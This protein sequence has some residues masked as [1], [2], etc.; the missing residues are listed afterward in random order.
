M[1]GPQTHPSSVSGKPRQNIRQAN[2]A[3]SHP[4]GSGPHFYTDESNIDQHKAA[5]E[6]H[7]LPATFQDAVRVTRELGLRYVWIDA[8]FIVRGPSGDYVKETRH[9]EE[10]FSSAYC[11][12]AATRAHSQLDGFLQPRTERNYR[13][14]ALSTTSVRMS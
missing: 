12:L 8:I 5:I 4:W 1:S 11:V 6:M 7:V 14:A 3:L 9:M 13:S 10:I 2:V